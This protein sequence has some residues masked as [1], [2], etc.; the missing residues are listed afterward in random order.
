MRKN[1]LPPHPLPPLRLETVFDIAECGGEGVEIFKEAGGLRPPASLRT[2]P[3][4]RP[5]SLAITSQLAGG[6]AGVGV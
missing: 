3:L 6:G 1:W 4:P 2:F 5:E